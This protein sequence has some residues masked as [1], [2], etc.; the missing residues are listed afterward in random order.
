MVV[1]PDNPVSCSVWTHP[2]SGFP[3]FPSWHS[4]FHDAPVNS[5]DTFRLRGTMIFCP[6]AKWLMLVAPWSPSSNPTYFKALPGHCYLC[7]YKAFTT[8]YS[9]YI[10][11]LSGIIIDFLTPSAVHGV[12][13]WLS[14]PCHHT[15]SWETARASPGSAVLMALSELQEHQAHMRTHSLCCQSMN[16]HKRPQDE[17]H[18]WQ[19]LHEPVTKIQ[20]ES[21]NINFTQ[22]K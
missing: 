22:G 14:L 19:E 20:R 21:S 13:P 1:L 5:Q 2:D 3:R 10:C 16:E 17:P 18:K 12:S 7:T 9:R 15:S 4:V 8:L 6:G 11:V